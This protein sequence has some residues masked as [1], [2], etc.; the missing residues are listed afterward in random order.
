M[1]RM[2]PNELTEAF[3]GYTISSERLIFEKASRE[4]NNDYYVFH[5]LRWY[6]P[7]LDD[8]KKEGQIDFIIAN[9]EYGFIC[10][11]VKGGRCSY[12]SSY[13]IWKTI[14]REDTQCTIKDPFIQ[15][16]TASRVIRKLISK[17]PKYK[18]IFLP[19]SHAV[20]FPECDFKAQNLR[21]DIKEWQILN[22]HNLNNFNHSIQHLFNNAFNSKISRKEG[23]L[24]ISGI[25][26]LYGSKNVEGKKT[27]AFGVH[28]SFSQLQALTEEQIS[29]LNQLRFQK[30]LLVRGCAGSGKT[31]LAIHK[32]QMTADEDKKVLLLCYNAPLGNYLKNLCADYPNILAGSFF[33]ICITWLKEIG[34]D[35]DPDGKDDDWWSNTLPEIIVKNIDNIPYRFD[36][37]IVDEG[38]DFKDTYWIV[39]ELL[40]ISDT[41]KV[42]YIFAD[43]NQN[44]YT[45]NPEFPS[46]S[47]SFMLN[48]NL[49]NTKE[50]F[51]T[52]SKCCDLDKKIET[53]GVPGPKVALI[54]YTNNKDMLARIEDKLM[55]FY[56]EGIAIH[57]VSVLGTRSQSKTCLKYGNKIGPFTLVEEVTNERELHTMTVHRFKGLE[58]KV[59]ILCELHDKVINLD[60]ILYIGMTRAISLLIIMADYSL[61]DQLASKIPKSDYINL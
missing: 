6:D 41:E 28:D 31:T 40:S 26:E 15:A 24:I 45:D 7:Q 23:Q 60:E 57:N 36:A 61:Y 39:I 16:S 56:N 49:R 47:E 17:E 30:Q 34:V 5:D 8:S 37:I 27:L 13:R 38:Q 12:D 29:L 20:I 48:R 50:I 11:E 43:N 9:P 22:I 42:L 14:N 55:V 59:V 33:D 51:S 25:K 52:V 53:S 46:K 19:N 35:I 3:S 10:L 54:K 18:E 32:A 44:I 58:N 21:A 2:F 4:L 1:A